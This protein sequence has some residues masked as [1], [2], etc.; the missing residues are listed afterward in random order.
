MKKKKQNKRKEKK[1]LL[2]DVLAAVKSKQRDEEIELYGKSI[3][4]SKVVRNKK[5]YSRKNY[6]IKIG[7]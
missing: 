7:E 2:K 4:Y 5:T 6:K 1:G 3:N